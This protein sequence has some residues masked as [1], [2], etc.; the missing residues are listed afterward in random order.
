MPI[1]VAPL[2][3]KRLM[4]RSVARKDQTVTLLR[5]LASTREAVG[6]PPV[7]R[8]DA[9][10]KLAMVY[11]SGRWVPSFDSSSLPGTKKADMET[12]ED[13]KGQ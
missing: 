11:E 4:S 8:Y 6:D 2:S 12:G 9:D 13:Q 10:R 1:C 5:R 3:V 7:V